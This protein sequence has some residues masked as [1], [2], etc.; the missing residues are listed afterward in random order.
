MKR[1]RDES[2]V[3]KLGW[4]LF[5]ITLLLLILC[6]CYNTLSQQGYLG[7]IANTYTPYVSKAE[8]PSPSTLSLVAFGLL[9]MG[10]KNVL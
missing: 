4:I 9:I 3:G 2:F 1:S 7:E 5:I 10:V 6:V 8:I